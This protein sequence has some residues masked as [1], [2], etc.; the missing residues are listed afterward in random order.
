[1]PDSIPAKDGTSD[2]HPGDRGIFNTANSD[3]LADQQ[4]L[5]TIA[6]N[7][8]PATLRDTGIREENIGNRSTEIKLKLWTAN[9][10]I[11]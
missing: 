8:L 3:S 11:D 9:T 10:D 6:V 4:M 5:L 2:R 1:M 7:G